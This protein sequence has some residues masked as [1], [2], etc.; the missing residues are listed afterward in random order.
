MRRKSRPSTRCERSLFEAM[1]TL[2]FEGLKKAMG[3]IMQKDE[4]EAV[5]HRRDRIIKL[6]EDR[7]AIRGEAAVLFTR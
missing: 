1:R 5:L 2:T 7:I 3:D 4:M 6:F